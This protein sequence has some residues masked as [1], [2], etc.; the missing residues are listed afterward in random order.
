MF[1]HLIKKKLSWPLILIFFFISGL[2]AKE[3]FL[4]LKNNKANV[5]YGPS[6]DSPVKYI[7][8]KKNLPLKEIDKKENFRRIIDLKK[9]SGWI[10]YSQLKPANSIIILDDKV[11]FKKPSNFS[12]PIARLEKGRLLVIKKCED[13]WCKITTGDYS[14]WIKTENVWGSAK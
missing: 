13:D 6:L 8:T 3:K 4:S 12:R 10:H 11:L 2:D 5:R 14:G 7:Y 9:N 1:M